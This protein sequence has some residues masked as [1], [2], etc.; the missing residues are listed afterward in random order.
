MASQQK[1][2]ANGKAAKG[3]PITAHPLFPAVVALW[4]GAL[5]GLGSLAIRVGLIES[6]A[7][8]SRIDLVIPAAAPPLGISAR[9]LLALGLAAGGALLGASIARRIAQPKP[10]VRERKRS[11]LATRDEP[12]AVRARDSHPDAP[13][14]RPI[15]ASEELGDRTEESGTVLL[16]GRRRTTL[17]IQ[18][19]QTFELHDFAPLPGGAPQ[20][21]QV[22]GDDHALDLADFADHD[23]HPMSETFAPPPPSERPQIHWPAPATDAAEVARDPISQ[24]FHPADPHQDAPSLNFSP[25]ADAATGRQV[26]GMTTP[27]PDEVLDELGITDAEYEDFRPVEIPTAEVSMTG[28]PLKDPPRA[29]GRGDTSK[30]AMIDLAEQLGLAL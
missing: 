15:S 29:E 2:S 9:I 22:Q 5:F 13:A 8:A 20:I 30:P 1:S 4:F 26:F 24:Q 25:P 6:L 21:H 19:E 3:K 23:A 28:E 16:G 10:E 7:L 18:H 27:Q 14:R 11:A 17:A 12:V